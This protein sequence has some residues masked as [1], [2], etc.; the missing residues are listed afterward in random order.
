MKWRCFCA[1]AL[2]AGTLACSEPPTKERQQAEGAIAAAR[3]AGAEAYAA[4]ELQAAEKALIDYDAAVEQRDYRQ[5]LRLAV[6]AR[7][8][9]Y[10]AAK[11]AADEKA[12]ARGEA[13]RLIASLDEW[14]RGAKARPTASPRSAAERQRAAIA[15]ATTALQKARSLIESQ[16]YPEA[17]ALLGP[18]IEATKK[19]TTPPPRRS[20]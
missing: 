17:I 10:E 12:A 2:A 18:A 13:E 4:T 1:V 3:A 5:A 9:A 6:E 16:H 14:L 7:N 19:E 11:R 15:G 8:G 20:P